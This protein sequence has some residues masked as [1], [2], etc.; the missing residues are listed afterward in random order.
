MALYT[1]IKYLILR[2]KEKMNV[3]FLNALMEFPLLF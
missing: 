3:L 1:N 2:I